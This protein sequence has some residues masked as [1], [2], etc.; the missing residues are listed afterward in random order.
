MFSIYRTGEATLPLKQAWEQGG[1]SFRKAVLRATHDIDHALARE[2]HEQGESR[3]GRTRI[4]FA[5]PVAVLFEIDD[6]G[7]RV[8]ILRA[9]AYGRA[10]MFE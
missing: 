5:E 6:A 10:P 9:W 2:P 4:L 1:E 8:N 3:E 7:R